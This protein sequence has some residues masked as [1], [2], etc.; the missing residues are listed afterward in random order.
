MEP[1]A[2]CVPFTRRSV[3]G[4]RLYA[5]IRV[6]GIR[7]TPSAPYEPCRMVPLSHV[8][9]QSD[10]TQD[11]SVTTTERSAVRDVSSRT[12]RDVNGP[13]LQF[14]TGRRRIIHQSA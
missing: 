8:D 11:P 13:S 6:S 9:P 12:R 7:R 4:G 2:T 3:C 5:C 14:L 1:S 10:V